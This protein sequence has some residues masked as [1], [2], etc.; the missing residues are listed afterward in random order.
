MFGLPLAFTAPLA[1]IGLLAL[2]IVWLLIRVTP[3]RPQ[4][5]P[6][7][8]IRILL[9]L[10]PQDETP[11]RTPPWL[12]LLRLALAALAVLAMA[13]PLWNPL[14]RPQNGGGAFLLV[15]DDGWAAAPSWD[16]RVAYA[17]AA[18]ED[19][20]RR[21]ATTALVAASDGARPIAPMDAAR[22]LERLRALKPA[23][24]TPDRRALL[25]PIEA[26]LAAQP[27]AQALWIADGL[28]RGEARAFAQSL[29][30]RS[31]GAVDVVEDA[32]APR[33][34]AGVRSEPGALA[35]RVLRA[36][37]DSAP[38]HAVLRAYDAKGR[39]LADAR[40]DFGDK[41]DAETRFELPVEIRNE[42]SR[43]AIE[44]E[45]SAGAVALLDE[46]WKRRRVGIVTG[47]G[48]DVAQPL[49]AP[50]Y[51]LTRALGPFAEVREARAGGADPIAALLD[52]HV[53]ALFLADVGVIPQPVADRLASFVENGGV[54]VRFAGS[55]LA[56]AQDEFTPV[57]LRRGGRI[58]GGALSWDTPKALAPFDPQGPFAGLQAP[59]E[60]TVSRQ[61]L[62][63]PEAGLPAKTWAHLADG[64]PLITAERRG[65]GLLVL[66]HVTA[67]TTW[68][69]LPLSGLFPQLLRKV[70]SMAGEAA[71]P[72]EEGDAAARKTADTLSPTRTLDGFGALG[73]PPATAKPVSAGA[74]VTAGPDHPP[75]FYGPPDALLAINTLEEDATLAPLDLSGLAA[76]RIVL[77]EAAP[78]DLR[79]PL[80]LLAAILFVADCLA[81]LWLSGGLPRGRRRAATAALALALL[82]PGALA[83][84]GDA[85][86]QTASPAP[87][88]APSKRDMDAALATR[89]A[90]VVTGDARV[91]EESR[92]GLQGLSRALALRTSLVPA[93]PAAL[94]PA[95]DELVF[96]PLIYW[97][98]AAGRP[99]PDRA[100]VEKIGAFMKGGGTVIF[101]TRDAG[102]ARAGG[103]PS[104]EQTWLRTLLAGVDVPELEPVPR[105]HVV[106][107]TFYL[108]DG[109]VGRT[110]NGQTWIEA[111][112]PER[113]DGVG[114]RPARAGDGVSPII[115]T[116]NGLAAAWAATPEGEPAYPLTPGGPRQR[117][118][119]LRGGVN[120]VMYTLTGNYKADQVHVRDLLERLGQ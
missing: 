113:G 1:L 56:A 14:A 22:S 100:A 107:K 97:P 78:V 32:H 45:A 88:P 35:V 9:A 117:E 57:P 80:I 112:P 52:E 73:V 44:G 79:G 43:V 63:D 110:T 101:D 40:V 42:I 60:V 17:A 85:Q 92:A 116:A 58:L 37:R 90:Y 61:V 118:M 30:G 103:P 95:R 104:P 94:D 19:A 115:I 47:A 49:L 74:G 4:T 39:P 82:A 18:L 111:L 28:E 5:V 11:A 65:K 46:R 62:A 106:T 6:F 67:D 12:L 38:Q 2:P 98:V 108:L 27:G 54:V 91:D 10:R 59:A 72:A 24:W 69:N 48:A 23:P 20:G 76:R 16:K 26:W 81:S 25:G 83:P 13:G 105:D 64:T 120:I 89:L 50:N 99:Q 33:A 96:Y 51:Y 102:T 34:L 93:E 8:P 86:A 55:R 41:L 3:P 29:A 109:F 87:K 84:R 7:P 31:N 36:G 68:S 15:L 53:S 70:V 71:R 77:A 114:Q 66:F 119:A 21:G 75:G